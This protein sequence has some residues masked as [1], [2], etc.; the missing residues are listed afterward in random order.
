MPIF[1]GL[2]FPA[3]ASTYLEQL[4]NLATL[5]LIPTSFIDNKIY[6]W[7]PKAIEA[8]SVNFEAVGIESEYFLENIGFALYII[9]LHCLAVFIHACLHLCRRKNRYIA[10][11]HGR[12]GRRYLYWNGLNR[13]YMELFFDI[14]LYAILN[15]HKVD[16]QTRF[17][18][19]QATN[20]VSI[21][22]MVIVCGIQIFYIV[23]YFCL[24]KGFRTKQFNA[25]FRPLLAGTDDQKDVKWYLILIPI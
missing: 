8:Y 7:P 11:V 20:A 2:K 6:Y 22:L 3:N 19:V 16:W 24:P 13:L 1:S 9:Y 12:L 21:I 18:S 25:N 23:K 4:I 17:P 5:D 15:L 14:V 10:R